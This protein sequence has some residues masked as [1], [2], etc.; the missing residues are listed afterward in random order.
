MIRLMMTTT[1]GKQGLVVSQVK[2][3]AAK[4]EAQISAMPVH[5]RAYSVLVIEGVEIRRCASETVWVVAPAGTVAWSPDMNKAETVRYVLAMILTL[6]R[7][8]ASN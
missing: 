2:A 7:R 8:A 1:A 3:M 5:D 4:I 6:A